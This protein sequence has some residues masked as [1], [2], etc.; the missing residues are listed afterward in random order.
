MDHGHKTTGQNA[1]V[2]RQQRVAVA[3]DAATSHNAGRRFTTTPPLAFLQKLIGQQIEDGL[4]AGVG[5]GDD[6][7][8]GGG[9]C[10]GVDETDNP[11]GGIGRL[12]CG[13]D[14]KQC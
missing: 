14:R 7:S 1:G 12:D 6:Q 8:V 10:V 9:T 13:L 2:A 4:R 11:E 5:L 3:S